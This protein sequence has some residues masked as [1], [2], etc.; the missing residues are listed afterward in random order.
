[1]HTLYAAESHPNETAD[2]A[3]FIAEVPSTM[4]ELVLQDYMV[5]HAESDAERLFYL[6]SALE[7][8][9]S[10]YVLVTILDELELAMYEAVERGEALSVVL[11]SN[12]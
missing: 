10:T 3:I 11:I 1:M 9:L 8:L 5:D 4:L 7:S 12:M 2:Y 6:G